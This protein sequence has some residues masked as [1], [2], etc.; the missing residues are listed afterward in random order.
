MSDI[1]AIWTRAQSI[2][3]RRA[4]GVTA[5]DDRRAHECAMLLTEALWSFG[6]GWPSRENTARLL[7]WLER[8]RSK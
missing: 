4:R 1:T 5:R 6:A 3:A 7:A 2:T 8:N